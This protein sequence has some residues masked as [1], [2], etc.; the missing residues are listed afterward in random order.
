MR[1]AA[2]VLAAEGGATELQ[3][4]SL[5]GWGSSAEAVGYTRAASKSWHRN[6][7]RTLIVR[8]H[9]AGIGCFC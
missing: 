4:M 6:W 1:K 8:T 7:H 9:S 5:F 2:A 3:L